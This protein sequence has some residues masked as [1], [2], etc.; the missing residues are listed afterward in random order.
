M[1]RLLKKVVKPFLPKYEVVCTNYQLV[2]G[3]PVNRNLSKHSFEKGAAQEAIEF[4]T[5]VVSS[6]FTKKMAPVE[7]HL[8]KRGK[9]I[10]KTA[11]GP[12]D[13]F[14]KKPTRNFLFFNF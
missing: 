11:F 1:K 9:T 3:L 6:E 14:Q 5:K 2:P 7:V 13:Q 4:Y 8:K 12:V 10:Q